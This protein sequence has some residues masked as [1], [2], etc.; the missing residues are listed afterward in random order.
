MVHVTFSRSIE[1]AIG[2]KSTAVAEQLANQAHQDLNSCFSGMEYSWPSL[3]NRISAYTGH[4]DLSMISNRL[5]I[6]VQWSVYQT[7]N[8]HY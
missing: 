6:T 1:R 5:N 2:I 3:Y 8:N 4:L 7:W